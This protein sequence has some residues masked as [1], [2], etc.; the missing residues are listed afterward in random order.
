M[1]A[2]AISILCG[3][4]FICEIRHVVV[5]KVYLATEHVD[6]NPTIPRLFGTFVPP[7]V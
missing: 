1:H 3:M 6:L 5:I 7:G 4:L 2:K